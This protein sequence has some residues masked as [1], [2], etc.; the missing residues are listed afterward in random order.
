VW[1]KHLTDPR[2]PETLAPKLRDAGFS[3]IKVDSIIQLEAEY[4]PASI[5]AVLMKFIVGYVESQGI[6]AS[7]TTAWREELENLAAKGEYFFNMNEYMFVGSV[8]D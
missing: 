3:D 1:G 7:E 5:S 8:G 6:A 2:L 4:D